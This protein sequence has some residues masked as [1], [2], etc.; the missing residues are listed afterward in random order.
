MKIIEQYVSCVNGDKSQISF[1]KLVYYRIEI[2]KYIAPAV[3]TVAAVVAPSQY[4]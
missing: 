3:A 1:V 4:I 2:D